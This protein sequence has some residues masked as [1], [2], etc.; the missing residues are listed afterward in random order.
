MTDYRP[1]LSPETRDDLT[2]LA[3]AQLYERYAQLVD[4]KYEVGI[5]S[6]E[7]DELNSIS[8][9]LDAAEASYYSRAKKQLEVAHEEMVAR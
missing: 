9:Y 6:E 3:A 8:F 4:K 5:S 7:V 2:L 1:T